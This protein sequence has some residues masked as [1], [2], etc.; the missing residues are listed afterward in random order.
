MPPRAR[1]AVTLVLGLLAA[2]LG[3]AGPAGAAT[4]GGTGAE[5]S[6]QRQQVI[7]YA[8]GSTV[9]QPGI[10]TSFSFASSPDWAGA[11]FVLNVLRHV[12]GYD[13]RVVGD[14]GVLVDPG[15][16]AVHAVAARFPVEPG[17][18]LGVYTITPGWPCLRFAEDEDAEIA[19]VV[20]PPSP[21]RPGDVVTTDNEYGGNSVNA[22]ARILPATTELLSGSGVSGAGTVFDLAVQRAETGE[23]TGTASFR[24]ASIPFRSG[25]VTCF[26]R[27]G[28]RALF[29][30]ADG[31]GRRLVYREFSVEDGGPGA[32]RLTGVGGARTTP[33]PAGCR[34]ALPRPGHGLPIAQGD[35]RL[36]AVP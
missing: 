14:T 30:I 11:R 18:R 3:S 16:G 21:P 19:L 4:I 13:F 1:L 29:G 27:S 10:L 33:P 35:I 32:D 24:N 26:R 6:C 9:S 12:Q 25:A 36:P 22:S 28:N 2:G 31:A 34:N 5:Q 17:D 8:A 7:D 23:L 20:G 15:D